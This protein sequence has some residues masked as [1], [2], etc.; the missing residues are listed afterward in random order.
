MRCV[1]SSSI[2]GS[3]DQSPA[4]RSFQ[5]IPVYYVICESFTEN[6]KKLCG[7]LSDVIECIL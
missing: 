7:K 5:I 1:A 2:S 3:H 6:K 4:G